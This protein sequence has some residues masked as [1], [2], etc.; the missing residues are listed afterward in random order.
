MAQPTTNR[1]CTSS[2]NHN[3]HC[4]PLLPTYDHSSSHSSVNCRFFEPEPEPL[5][6]QQHIW[7]SHKFATIACSPRSPGRWLPG[8][9]V[10]RANGQLALWFP[11]IS[12]SRLDFRQTDADTLCTRTWLS[13]YGC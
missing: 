6:P 7:H 5:A 1:V 2:A 4:V 12:A 10:L 8:I 9:G 11:L 13:H 3:Q